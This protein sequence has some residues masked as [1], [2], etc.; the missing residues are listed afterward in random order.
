MELFS[1]DRTR[2]KVR[3]FYEKEV[4]YMS[5]KIIKVLGIAATAIGIAANILGD[6]A[7]KKQSESEMNDAID[8]AVKKALE[9]EVK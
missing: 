7:G 3:F 2:E 6:W 8:K 4:T 9:K 1:F 5:P